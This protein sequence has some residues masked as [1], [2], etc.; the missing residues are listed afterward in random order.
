MALPY[1][2]L[3]E[4]KGKRLVT[5]LSFVGIMLGVLWI[6]F[7]SMRLQSKVHREFWG[8]ILTLQVYFYTIFPPEAIWFNVLFRLIG[9]GSTVITSMILGMV[10]DAVSPENR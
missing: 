7:V 8:M 2:R 5:F 1:G 3:A 6:L 4:V 10:A 9:G